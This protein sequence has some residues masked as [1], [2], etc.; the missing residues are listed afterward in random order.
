MDFLVKLLFS[1]E[2]LEAISLR[3]LAK[4]LRGFSTA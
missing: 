3:G 2:N 1:G 4:E